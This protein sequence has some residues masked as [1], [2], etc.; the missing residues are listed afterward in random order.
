MMGGVGGKETAEVRRYCCWGSGR[1]I[2]AQALRDDGTVQ[3]SARQDR[4][5]EDGLEALFCKK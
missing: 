5:D 3:T 2:R 4:D 1:E